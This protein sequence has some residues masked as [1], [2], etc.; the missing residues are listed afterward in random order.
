[1]RIVSIGDVHGRSIWKQIVEKEKNADKIVFIGDYLDVYDNISSEV[2]LENLNEII[3]FKKDNPDQV[4]LLFGNHDYHYLDS[5]MES[6]S[7][8]QSKIK[9]SAS[10]ILKNAIDENLIQ[11]CFV[12]DDY[13]YSHAGITK[14]WANL[15]KID[16]NNIQNCINEKLKYSPNIF[17][18]CGIDPHG[19]DITQSPIWVRPESL[20][21]D[22]LEG[23]K[24]IVGHTQQMKITIDQ[25]LFLIDNHGFNSEYLIINDGNIEINKI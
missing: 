9:K 21:L 7:G 5:T 20:K 15:H 12:F 13:V 24:F 6:Y 2:Q 3:Q 23:Y 10:Q 17:S 22:G 11:V 16:L 25:N 19:D 1:M 8:F 14:T 4:I 18:F